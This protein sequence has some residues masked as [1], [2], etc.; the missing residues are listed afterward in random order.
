[1]KLQGCHRTLKT[2]KNYLAVVFFLNLLLL[3]SKNKD[4]EEG[5]IKVYMQ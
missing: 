1:M 5:V 3:I 2:F 4:Q